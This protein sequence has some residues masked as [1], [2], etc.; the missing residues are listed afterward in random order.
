MQV[1][2]ATSGLRVRR[3]RIFEAD[4]VQVAGLESPALNDV[5]VDGIGRLRNVGDGGGS[6]T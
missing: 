2:I 3:L 4:E 6:H 1:V 5:L